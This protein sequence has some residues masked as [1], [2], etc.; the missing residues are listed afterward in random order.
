MYYLILLCGLLWTTSSLASTATH[1]LWLE[2]ALRASLQDGDRDKSRK[3]RNALAERNEW[4]ALRPNVQQDSY[5]IVNIAAQRVRLVEYGQIT[6]DEKVIIG[7]DGMETPIFDDEIIDIVF[8][9]VWNIPPD[10]A[11]DMLPKMKAVGGWNGYN[12]YVDG[13]LTDNIDEVEA[14]MDYRIIQ[15]AS[16]TNALGTLKFNSPNKYGV[17]LH[18]TS[19]HHLFNEDD[20]RFSAGC[21]RVQNSNVLAARI[22]N[23]D[24]EAIQSSI[25]EKTTFSIPLTSPLKVFIVDWKVYFDEHEKLIYN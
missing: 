22:L 3:I 4:F 1:N 24:N 12:I 2:D 20:R 7:R 10:L 18:D 9:P 13:Q 6:F 16:E 25:D 23:W 15:D 14:G 8:N 19:S 17:Y 5:V 21:V 11:D